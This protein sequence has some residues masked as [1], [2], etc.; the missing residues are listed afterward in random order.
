MPMEIRVG[1]LFEATD[2]PA[3][4]HGCNCAGS[5]GKGIA[6]EFRRR[7]PDMYEAYRARCKEGRFRPG[8]VFTWDADG[9]TIFNLATQRSPRPSARLEYIDDS[10][11]KAITIAEARRIRTVGMPRMGAGLGG[12]NWSDVKGVIE[13]IAGDT[14]IALVV[15]ERPRSA[16]SH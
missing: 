8:D 7:W 6:A 14:P 1:D 5:M 9:K 11:R 4:A 13:A 3:L 2:L 15:Y 10:L 16:A 12:L